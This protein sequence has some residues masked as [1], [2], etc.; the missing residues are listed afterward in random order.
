[1]YL[2]LLFLF[3]YCNIFLITQKS[4]QTVFVFQ[5]FC[6]YIEV[7]NNFCS[8]IYY[9]WYRNSH[10]SFLTISIFVVYLFCTLIFNLFMSLYLK[11]IS[12]GLAH[13]YTLLFYPNFTLWLLT[14]IF[15]L[16]TFNIII[17]IVGFKSI[18][19][20][21]VFHMCYKHFYV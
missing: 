19:L 9:I 10:L 18:I 7:Y 6:Q 3:P 5:F 16:F 4:Q 11:Y 2:Y 13:N 8:K 14:V 17:F 15:R 21:F 12:C 20:R 1:M